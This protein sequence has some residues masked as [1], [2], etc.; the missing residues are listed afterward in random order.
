MAR[1]KQE[2]GI[3]A[4]L[5][6]CFLRHLSEKSCIELLKESEKYKEDII[7]IGLVSVEVGNPPSKF[8]NLYALAKEMGYRLCAHAGEEG[9][10]EYIE[11]AID[12][13]K[14]ERIDHGFTAHYSESLMKRLAEMNIPLTLCP[15]SNKLLNVCPDL[16]Q[17]PLKLFNDMGI[18]TTINS[19]DPAFFNGNIAE[20]Y[21]ELVKE[22]GLTAEDIIKLAKNSILASFLDEERKLHHIELID[23]FIKNIYI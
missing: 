9:G 4:S 13:L 16:R 22:I 7:A 8:K 5:I 11:E 2:F 21:I 14:C 6:L 18:I 1:V 19:D 20:N 15:L 17:Y 10:P 3:D 12:I 23:K